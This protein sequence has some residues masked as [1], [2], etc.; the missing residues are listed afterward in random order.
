MLSSRLGKWELVSTASQNILTF[1]AGSRLSRVAELT[2]RIS[3][4]REEK[5]RLSRGTLLTL[6]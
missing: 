6:G 5:L 1:N 3:R 4:E 2:R